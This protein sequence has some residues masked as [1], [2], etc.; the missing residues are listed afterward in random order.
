MKRPVSDVRDGRNPRQGAGSG[1]GWVTRTRNG[2]MLRWGRE[3][4]LAM[5]T[6]VAAVTLARPDPGAP[7]GTP[8][9]F[10]KSLLE[11]FQCTFGRDTAY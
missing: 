8:Y 2:D 5:L 7:T 9:D 10:L 4:V 3:N 1:V 6:K 11:F